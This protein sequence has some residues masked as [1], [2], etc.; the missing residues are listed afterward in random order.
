MRHSTIFV[1]IFPVIL[2]MFMLA[3]FCESSSAQA[4]NEAYD[5]LAA[6]MEYFQGQQGVHNSEPQARMSGSLY[7]SISTIEGTPPEEA[8]MRILVDSN[9]IYENMLR[10]NNRTVYIRIDD[11]MFDDPGLHTLRLTVDH[12]RR[13]AEQLRYNNSIE[14]IVDVQEP[15]PAEADVQVGQLLY[16]Q[17]GANG[18]NSEPYVNERGVIYVMLFKTPGEANVGDVETRIEV[19]GQVIEEPVINVSTNR[20]G[21]YRVEGY[22]FTEP[23]EHTIRLTVDPDNRIQDSDRSNNIR[24]VNVNARILC[25]FTVND[26]VFKDPDDNEIT[27]ISQMQTCTLYATFENNSG[28][29]LDNV[30]VRISVNDEPVAEDT[31]WVAIGYFAYSCEHT[32]TDAGT[33]MVRFMV[34]PDNEMPEENMLNNRVSRRIEVRPLFDISAGELSCVPADGEGRPVSTNEPARVRATFHTSAGAGIDYR[35]RIKAVIQINGETAAERVFNNVDPNSAFSFEVP[36]LIFPKAWAQTLSLL[37]D[38]DNEIYEIRENN[39]LTSINVNVNDSTPVD[40]EAFSLTFIPSGEAIPTSGVTAGTSGT[41]RGE[42]G[43]GNDRE[44]INFVA[45]L[46]RDGVQLR[47][48][49]Y[50]AAPGAI[51]NMVINNLVLSEPGE[52]V[53]RLVVSPPGFYVESDENNNTQELTINVLPARDFE[54]RRITFSP[55]KIAVGKKGKARCYVRNRSALRQNGIT[56][57]LY[58]DGQRIHEGVINIGPNDELLFEVDDISFNRP[59]RSILLL[60][61]DP[62]NNLDEADENNN[63][64]ETAVTVTQLPDIEVRDLEFISKDDSYHAGTIKVGGK[65]DFKFTIKN[66]GN[67]KVRVTVCLKIDGYQLFK[68]NLNIGPNDTRTVSKKHSFKKPGKLRVVVT[69]DPD[70]KIS[71]SSEKNNSLEKRIVVIGKDNKKGPKDTGIVNKKLPLKK[72]GKLNVV[73][74]PDPVNKIKKPGKKSDSLKK[75]IKV[76]DKDKKEG[77]KDK[78]KN[79]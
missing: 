8:L 46:E 71:E 58:K 49:L 15:A 30:R 32:F 43:A 3:G 55:S 34:N 37:L 52:H 76:I 56:A 59:G 44:I 20:P 47:R 38:P 66:A 42:F 41:L 57:K 25:D 10:F 48:E 53:F 73:V 79:F 27:Y 77:P 68:G 23:G 28:H 51:E 60:S 13:T 4:E 35:P 67:E 29:V 64:C 6:R 14:T 50:R 33:A 7:A 54:A 17:G 22:E 2:I 70:N 61:V 18:H 39:N 75:R 31:I 12:G 5:L 1:K 65:G 24:E 40:A 62:D 72:P 36:D 74:T 11:F 9:I 16:L 45:I 21:F 63:T 78:L 19:D 26:M 69:A